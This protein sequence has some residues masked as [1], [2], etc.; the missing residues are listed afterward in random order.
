MIFA[1][2]CIFLAM[3]I[4]DIINGIRKGIRIQQTNR[5]FESRISSVEQKQYDFQNQ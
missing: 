2:S 4:R 3:G 5:Q 1:S